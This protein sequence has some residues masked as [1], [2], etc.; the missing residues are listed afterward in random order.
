MTDY[1]QQIT[2]LYEAVEFRAPPAPDLQTYNAELSSGLITLSQLPGVIEQDPFTTNVV[3]A[4]IREYQAAFG[5]VP[6]QGGLAYWVGVVATNPFA[7]SNLNTIFAN[8]AE[9]DARYGA[10]ASTPA[11]ATLVTALYENVLGRAP[12]D[13]G[14]AY[15]ASSGLTAAQLL[16]AFAQSQEFISDAQPA[17]IAYENLEAAGAPPTT[18]SLLSLAPAPGGTDTLTVGAAGITV[19]EST[20]TTF[21][22]FDFVSSAGV[23]P[24]VVVLNN[25]STAHLGDLSGSALGALTITNAA[26]QST[27][28]YGLSGGASD[29]GVILNGPITAINLTSNGA[30][31]NTFGGGP[32]ISGAA[33][34]ITV[35]ITGDAALTLGHFAA[36][37][38]GEIINAGSFSGSLAYTTSGYGDVVNGGSGGG[39]YILSTPNQVGGDYKGDFINLSTTHAEAQIIINAGA[40]GASI[41]SD[42]N[43]QGFQT[44]ANFIAGQD[45]YM[46]TATSSHPAAMFYN[47]GTG[48]ANVVNSSTLTIAA[49]NAFAD[50]LAAGH[51]TQAQHEVV[52]F[53]WQGSTYLYIEQDAMWMSGIMQGMP[54]GTNGVMYMPG[55]P[56]ADVIVKEVGTVGAH[57]VHDFLLS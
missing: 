32:G 54:V 43:A 55:G 9:F 13:G 30:A 36:N 31:A 12:D 3:D 56:M 21:S 38:A 44:V 26:G 34:A 29:L 19:D 11:T 51:L 39:F 37:S 14:L 28:N 53:Q 7:L 6:D 16:Q 45:V 24:N 48:S 52:Q 25:T 8:S 40:N 23:M 22:T 15:W 57:T 35:T 10:N 2:N 17:I 1:T 47:D 4:V 20:L 27:L 49:E 42:F 33:N 18:G 41:L 50:G 5:R 46:A